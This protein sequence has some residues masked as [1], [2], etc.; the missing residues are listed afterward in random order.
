MGLEQLWNALG[1]A[2]SSDPFAQAQ[3]NQ[4]AVQ[5]QLGI[6]QNTGNLGMGL[7][8]TGLPPNYAYIQPQAPQAPQAP[9]MPRPRTNLEWLDEQIDKVRIPLLAA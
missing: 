7:G 3:Q 6:M 9:S 5:Q 1:V 8:Y 4:F 2:T